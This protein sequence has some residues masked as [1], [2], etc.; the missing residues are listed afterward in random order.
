MTNLADAFFVE[1][2]PTELADRMES[3]KSGAKGIG[4]DAKMREKHADFEA[5]KEGWKSGADAYRSVWKAW[6]G[7]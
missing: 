4:I 5:W 1:G 6:K 3:W 7:L 2:F